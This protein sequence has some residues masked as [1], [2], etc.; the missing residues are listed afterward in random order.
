MQAMAPQ[1]ANLGVGK[2]GE[3]ELMAVVTQWAEEVLAWDNI[4]DPMMKIYME[5]FTEEE[6][7]EITRFYQTPVGQK[8]LEKMPVLMQKGVKVGMELAEL[9]QERLQ[10]DIAAVIERLQGED[11]EEEE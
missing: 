9:H 10:E 11:E 2:E 8:V 3:K 1:F 5:E 7:R 6:L 4:R